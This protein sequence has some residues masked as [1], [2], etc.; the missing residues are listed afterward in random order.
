M[1]LLLSTDDRA[2]YLFGGVLSSLENRPFIRPN[3]FEQ[4]WNGQLGSN[5]RLAGDDGLM[6]PYFIEK[7]TADAR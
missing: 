7:C 3:L 4:L 1:S 6:A 5:R 2:V